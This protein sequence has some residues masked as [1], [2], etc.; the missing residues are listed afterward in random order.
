MSSLFVLGGARSGKSRFAIAHHASSRRVAFVA[1][2]PNGAGMAE[3]IARHQAE[4][5]P[6]WRTVEEPLDPAA[7]LRELDGKVDG[8]IVDCL[9]LWVSNLIDRGDTDDA[10]LAAGRALA[11]VMPTCRFDVTVG[12]NEVGQEVHPPTEIGLR[13][14]D[15]MGRVNQDIA[16][17]C[18]HVVLMVAGLPLTLK[19]PRP[20]DD[21][22]V[23]A[24]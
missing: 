19:A 17:A 5:P 15:L 8:A 22:A 16:A 21:F 7:R 11:S 9:T 4:R 12:S 13:F 1:T 2:A 23:Q 18:D 6:H 24:P 10:I 3:R 20:T 14:R